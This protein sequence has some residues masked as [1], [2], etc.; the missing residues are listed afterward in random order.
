MPR[1]RQIADIPLVRPPRFAQGGGAADAFGGSSAPGLAI[2][3]TQRQHDLAIQY[4]DDERGRFTERI[5]EFPQFAALLPGGF[6]VAG[7][8]QSQTV[9]VVSNR[10]SFVRLVAIRGVVQNSSILPLSGLELAQLMLR[11]QINGEE[12]LTT[13]GTV[14][15]PASFAALFANAAA[16]WLWFAAP[17]RLRVGD[18]LMATVTNNASPDGATLTPEVTCR[19]VDDQW[20]RSLYGS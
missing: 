16:P 15:N 8:T 3:L 20:W 2:P 7:A 10:T 4:A 11:F 19:L 14:S 18:T 1:R 17:P 9:Q 5:F 6:S 13:S 12:D